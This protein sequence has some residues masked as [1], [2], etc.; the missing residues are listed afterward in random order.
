MAVGQDLSIAT[1]DESG[2]LIL[3]RVDLEENSAAVNG[4][5]NVDGGEV[6]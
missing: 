4:A 2:A 3:G 5:G 6:G 1:D